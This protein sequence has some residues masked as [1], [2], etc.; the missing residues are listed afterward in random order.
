M[1]SASALD[2]KLLTPYLNRS[3]SYFDFF[4]AVF[5]LSFLSGF[6][7]TNARKLAKYI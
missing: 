1:G 7:D 5:F 4:P 3:I 6:S 2:V